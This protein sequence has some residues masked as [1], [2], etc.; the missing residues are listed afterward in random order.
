MLNAPEVLGSIKRIRAVLTVVGTLRCA[1]GLG[2]D[3]ENTLSGVMAA[4]QDVDRDLQEVEM[5]LI[6][7][8]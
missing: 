4:L 5:A 6:Q 8:I 2:I 1:G 7:Y 3:P